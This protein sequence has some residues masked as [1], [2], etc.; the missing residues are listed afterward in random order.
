MSKIRTGNSNRRRRV[1]LA[2]SHG[3]SPESGISPISA[4]V[5]LFVLLFILVLCVPRPASAAPRSYS[6]QTGSFLTLDRAKA[7]FDQLALA[8]D[9]SLLSDLR[10][11]KWKK[12]YILRFGAFPVFARASEA[13]ES[14]KKLAG[15]AFI[16][17]DP[18]RHLDNILLLFPDISAS[19]E[20]Y[21]LDAGSFDTRE[22]ANHR[23]NFLKRSMGQDLNGSP[24]IVENEGSFLVICGDFSS[25]GAARKVRNIVRTLVREVRILDDAS[26]GAAPTADTASSAPEKE[27]EDGPGSMAEEMAEEIVKPI[28]DIETRME[29][30]LD[31]QDYGIAVE[32]IKKAI[33]RW[34]DNPELYAWYGTTLISMDRPDKALEYYQ[35]A[36][37]LAP[38]VPDY[39]SNVGYSHMHMHMNST[40]R[41]IDSFNNALQL[42]PDNPD[43]LEG[44]GTVYVSI[45]ER[46]LAEEME[47][48]LKDLDPEAA[49][50]L[51]GLIQNGI[52]WDD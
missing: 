44:L 38:V 29:E 18:P 21:S 1:T 35:K 15:D 14:A 13:L 23:L 9:K 36:A 41:A 40:K 32:L 2:F 48:R 22:K 16:L 8:L 10:I 34:P 46:Q 39:Q 50:R 27:K 24:R 42:E 52:N 3:M 11:V 26:I 43:A 19:G 6:V 51:S 49:E 31:N 33:D 17:N 45:G 20:S 25:L 4:P 7:Q 47:N 12:Y 5:G 30:L 37:E 28:E